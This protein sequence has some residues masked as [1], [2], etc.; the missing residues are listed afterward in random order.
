MKKNEIV[1]VVCLDLSDLGAGICRVN[2]EVVFV[3][4]LLP[5]EVAK[6]KIIKTYSKYAIG[7]VIERIVDSPAR[8]KEPC[9]VARWCGGC[10]LQEVRYEDQ[11][12]FKNEWL[13][14]LFPQENLQPIIGSD[15]DL[16]Y[17]NKAQFPMQVVDHEVKMGFYR[18]HSNSIV[19]TYECLIQNDG[20][21][22]IYGLLKDEIREEE[23]EGLRHLFIR[24]SQKTREGQ[25]VWIGSS[26]KKLH[27][28]NTLLLKNFPWIKSI[29]FNYNRRQDN[30]IL[31]DEYK[32]LYG[33]DWIL[34]ECLGNLVRLH[35]KSFF[36]VNPKQMEVLYQI[37]ID[38]ADLKKSDRC[39]ELYAGTGTIGM[40][41]SK[42]VKEVIGV[43]IVPE[44]V[45][46]AKANVELNGIENCHYICQ[47][48][49]QFV[50]AFK[51]RCDVLFVDP[52]RKGMSEEG[53]GQIK[54]ISPRKVVYISCNPKTLKR[55]IERFDLIGYSCS[56]LQP[57]DM[58]P[59]TTGIECVALLTKKEI[60]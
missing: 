47:D 22:E 13:K 3:Y 52:P 21:N 57:V 23:A 2:N 16:F 50:K 14:K 12:V 56:I 58:F 45:E 20:I 36:Q 48:A 24:V 27:R 37:A 35:F 9:P 15:L 51:K 46:N 34:E 17:R 41:I 29:V 6:I 4:D 10:Q 8:Q 7:K 60:E 32:V 19:D 40:A 1:E 31:G 11:L 59:Y 53:I 54:E 49:S 26:E 38:L 5:S 18:L 42:Y 39:I 28:L 30:V 44:A 33:K 55:D 43:E 25:V